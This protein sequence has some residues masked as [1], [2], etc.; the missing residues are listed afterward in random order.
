MGKSIWH[1]LFR[2]ARRS[3]PARPRVERLE[4][5]INPTV[6]LGPITVTGGPVVEGGTITVSGTY[7]VFSPIGSAQLVID[8]G[9]NS[10]TQIIPAIEGTNVPF[11][12]SHVVLDDVPTATPQ[13]TVTVNVRL[14]DTGPRTLTPLDGGKYRAYDVPSLNINLGNA[15]NLVGTASGVKSAGLDD[16][17]DAIVQVPLGGSFR[18]YGQ[19]FTA[20]NAS[21]NG[22]LSFNGQ[23][24]SGNNTS[25]NSTGTVA[26]IAP[27]WDDLQ[28]NTS[29]TDRVL[30][31]NVD[32]DGD[33]VNDYFIIEWH[34]V[35]HAGNDPTKTATFQALLQLNTGSVN[36]DI[37]FNYI[38]TDFGNALYN[39]GASATIGIQSGGTPQKG[40]TSLNSFGPDAFKNNQAVRF[41]AQDF[42]T[43]RLAGPEG[44]GYNAF[45]TPFERR[46]DITSATAT[47]GVVQLLGGA[48]AFDDI[49]ANAAPVLGPL[50][51]FNFY[52]VE[53]DNT[54]TMNVSDNG[55]IVFSGVNNSGNNTDLTATPAQAAIAALWDAWA[56]VMDVSN[57]FGR[58]IDFDG[59]GQGEFLCIEW[60]NMQ[61]A[62]ATTEAATWQALLELNTD[63]LDPGDIYLNYRDTTVGSASFN[64]GA[65][66]TVGIKDA[67][68]QGGANAR[69]LVV[70]RGT[71]GAN[72][73]DGRAVGIFQTTT[74][75][76]TGTVV[77]T[78]VPPTLNVGFDVT[79]NEGDQHVRTITF[80][81]VSSANT[82]F[83]DTF[84][85]TID[86]GDGSA[87]QNGSVG[88]G[89]RSFTFSH[90]YADDG[91]YT[92]K[93]TLVDDDT[94]A[95][96]PGSFVV[97]VLNVA[98][99]IT[100]TAGDVLIRPQ[101]LVQ[102]PT[103][104]SFSDPG[105]TYAPAGTKEVFETRID[106][107]D[108]SAPTVMKNFAGV[109]GGP[110]VPTT[111]SFG[112]Q[113]AYLSPGTFTVTVTVTDDDGGV[114]TTTLL[115]G[116]GSPKL[117]V[118]GADAGGGPLVVAFDNKVNV[119]EPAFQ[120]YAFD[121]NFRG[122]VRVASGDINGDGLADIVTA[123]GP[124]GGPHV[125][126][127]DGN[128]GD[129]LQSFFAYGSGFTGGVYIAVG[130]VDGDSVPD[131][132][133]GAGAG[134]GPHVKVF[135]GATGAEIRSFFAYT[136]SFLGG[137]RVAT[138]DVNGDG[139]SDIIT[140]AGAGGGPHV[141][142]F[143]GK[144]G[145]VISE[146]FAYP[147]SFLGGVNVTAGDINNDGV[148]ELV[149]GPGLGGGPLARVFN[150]LTGQLIT[151]FN[152]FPPGVPGQT[153]P[154]QGD[155]LWSSGLYVGVTD[156]GGDGILD[157]VVGPGA[158]RNSTVRLFDGPT[159]AQVR[160]FRVFDPSF[161]GGVFVGGN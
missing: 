26:L 65:S 129:V 114:A 80:A 24:K 104:A 62:G 118:F 51:T 101:S 27:F 54:S 20:T 93:I 124:G 60:S 110:G 59:D 102:F 143:S 123:A 23:N 15:L 58:V 66:A 75:A 121:P 122:G 136:A 69:R 50:D 127:F 25:L 128:T 9:D 116:V 92:A 74:P 21:E 155:Q 40:F 153:P 1:S 18:F 49:S 89:G 39:F 81:D 56:G 138:A 76:Q 133:T 55:L 30:Y 103:I 3:L 97:T 161:L 7:T 17:N 8:W 14:E 99:T 67:G 88:Q 125:K 45:P 48:G 4:S 12:I 57:V 126:V 141:R 52:G 11:S 91:K 117:T 41:S 90:F 150:G 113:H 79:I 87:I 2:P 19:D 37:I 119:T 151:Q 82:G 63:I 131:I 84:T 156:L 28:T 95:A 120:F 157:V 96:V 108:G 46:L 115:V 145:S 61:N 71:N 43:S 112:G 160:E 132:V 5:I 47:N 53:Y 148:V 109:P 154:F 77:V 144:T 159:L 140:G 29:L 98:P 42:T 68:P 149:T 147:A 85:Y 33:G 130:D 22:L 86:F 31:R 137:V 142:V 105:Y 44:F 94:G 38:D 158:G 64:A 78:N 107:G 111:G 139:F 83:G 73:A 100:F 135:S 146:F 106:W 152:A 134:G 35:P 10:G 16:A 70:P 6:S 32:L 72:F 13:D 36:G 34:N